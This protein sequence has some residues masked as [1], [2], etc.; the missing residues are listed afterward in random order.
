MGAMDG[1]SKYFKGHICCLQ[2]Y[3]KA[4]SEQ[5]II[6]VWNR[7][8]SLS[9]SSSESLFLSISSSYIVIEKNRN[10]YL[11]THLGIELETSQTE[12]GEINTLNSRGA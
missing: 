11:R 4:L 1:L 12:G 8:F 5:E 6:A 2:V 9:G 7:T 3:N 10:K